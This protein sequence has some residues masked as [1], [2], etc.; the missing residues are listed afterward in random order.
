[1]SM[2][3]IKKIVIMM[4]LCVINNTFAINMIQGAPATSVQGVSYNQFNKN[5]R[6]YLIDPF[7]EVDTNWIQ[8]ALMALRQ[9]GLYNSTGFLNILWGDI[10]TAAKYYAQGNQAFINNVRRSLEYNFNSIMS[11]FSPAPTV[12]QQPVVKREAPKPA[13]VVKRLPE[14]PQATPIF[15]PQLKEMNTERPMEY[16]Y[17]PSSYESTVVDMDAPVVKQKQEVSDRAN[18]TLQSIL[19]GA[20]GEPYTSKANAVYNSG[21][22]YT[23]ALIKDLTATLG[24]RYTDE[25]RRIDNLK[26]NIDRQ[27]KFY[28]SYRKN[29]ST[30]PAV[31]VNPVAPGAP[32]TSVAPAS[33][34]RVELSA[35]ARNFVGKS[36]GS[37]IVAMGLLRED[38]MR[39]A[40]DVILG[41]AALSNI[42][43]VYVIK[44]LNTMVDMLVVESLSRNK[45]LTDVQRAS[46]IAGIRNQIDSYVNSRAR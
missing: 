10:E 6:G 33:P 30:V 46:L 24:A 45:N 41:G 11:S 36:K 37:Q 35:N 19:N 39:Q 34:V 9:D 28:E 12:M 3:N 14:A 18:L 20:L 2:K 7:G 22:L 25:Q 4:T 16:Y 21:T 44:D 38:W 31:A 27:Y 29:N 42:N 17:M 1:M 40:I 15:M 13:P 23:D 5:Y 43:K 26:L 32:V 8:G